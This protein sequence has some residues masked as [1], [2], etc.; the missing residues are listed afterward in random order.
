MLTLAQI[1]DSCRRKD[2]VIAEQGIAFFLKDIFALDIKKI[3]IREDSLSLNSVNGIVELATPDKKSGDSKLFFK[4]HHEENESEL[5]EYYNSQLLSENNF[6]IDVPI[7]SSQ[8]VGKQILLYRVKHSRRFF[9]LCKE[10]DSDIKNEKF[11]SAVVA[12]IDLDN[13]CCEKYIASLHE[14]SLP[15]LYEEPI[16][17]LFSRRL[18]DDIV[19]QKDK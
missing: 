12:Q 7:Y 16:L 17:Q 13:I 8:E 1:Q 11:S 5:K 18:S 10:L 9:D 3:T 2:F 4:F 15:D 14:A 19:T 6:P